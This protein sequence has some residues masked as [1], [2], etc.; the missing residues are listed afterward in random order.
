MSLSAIRMNVLESLN[1][2]RNLTSQSTFNDVTVIDLLRDR[3]KFLIA[4]CVRSAIGINASL[5]QDL[6]GALWADTV[7]VLE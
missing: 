6:L 2:L 5:F 1:V 7:D 4:K 3:C